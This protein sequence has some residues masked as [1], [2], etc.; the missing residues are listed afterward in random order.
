MT[1][2]FYVNE[3]SGMPNVVDQSLVVIGGMVTGKTV[4]STKNNKMMA[5]IQ[6]EDLLGTV[7]V[8]IFRMIMRNTRLS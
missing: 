6:L 4:K 1:S 5:F 3:E 7:E 8:I 2:D